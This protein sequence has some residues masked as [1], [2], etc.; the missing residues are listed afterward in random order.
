M[1]KK[2]YKGFARRRL[3]FAGVASQL[4]QAKRRGEITPDNYRKAIQLLREDNTRFGNE[5]VGAVPPG[6]F[7]GGKIIDWIRENWLEILKVILTILPLFL[8]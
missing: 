7:D 2:L 5:I 4:R 3:I 8:I 6:E 1:S